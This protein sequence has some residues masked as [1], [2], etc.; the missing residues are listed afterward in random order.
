MQ[1]V[2]LELRTKY[3]ISLASIRVHEIFNDV[4]SG[5]KIDVSA[6]TAAATSASPVL[7]TSSSGVA[8]VS[9]S[10]AGLVLP[11]LTASTAG[12]PAASAPATGVPPAECLI[13]AMRGDHV[14]SGVMENISNKHIGIYFG[15]FVWHYSNSQ[16]KVVSQTLSDFS[17]HYGSGKTVLY[18]TDFPTGATAVEFATASASALPANSYIETTPTQGYPS[19]KKNP[20]YK[21]TAT[22][23]ATPTASPFA[24]PTPTPTASPF[25]KPTPFPTP[26]LKR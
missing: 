23:T 10:S 22:P 25:A 19:L 16:R 12:G 17:S 4:G 20:K 6:A 14:T 5:V 11:T 24:S 8:A 7:T 18:Y 21:P 13:Y 15:G 3:S 9:T 26:R 2:A 1:T